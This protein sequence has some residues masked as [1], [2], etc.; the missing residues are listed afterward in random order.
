M[1]CTVAPFFVDTTFPK[2]AALADWLVGVG[3]TS[4]HGEIPISQPRYDVAT[5]IAPTQRWVYEKHH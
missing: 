1:T 5:V 2:G 4:T 3:A